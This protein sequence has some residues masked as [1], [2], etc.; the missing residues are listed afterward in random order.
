[1]GSYDFTDGVW[2]WPEGLS[3]YVEIHCVRL[4]AEFIDHLERRGFAYPTKVTHDT[5][6]IRSDAQQLWTE[7]ERYQLLVTESNKRD[8]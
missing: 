7:S 5:F 4:P 3:H 2:V 8:T 1:M 6:H